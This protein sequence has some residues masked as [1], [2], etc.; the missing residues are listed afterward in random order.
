MTAA[1][2]SD[3]KT[4][5][6]RRPAANIVSPWQVLSS[7]EH[8][9]TLSKARIDANSRS[10]CL[11]RCASWALRHGRRHV[12]ESGSWRTESLGDAHGS[13]K[14]QTEADLLTRKCE[15]RRETEL[16]IQKVVRAMRV[17]RQLR[18]SQD[19]T[20]GFTCNRRQEKQYKCLSPQPD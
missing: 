4:Q 17:P 16:R 7:L 15:G 18:E 8:P 1:A 2:C 9:C 13:E 20:L 6:G 19:P 3:G 10:W 14:E 12:R 5:R 11:P